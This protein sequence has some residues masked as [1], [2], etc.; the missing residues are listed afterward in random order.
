LLIGDDF[1][2]K[3]YIEKDLDEKKDKNQWTQEEIETLIDGIS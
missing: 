2:F 1:N 3:Q